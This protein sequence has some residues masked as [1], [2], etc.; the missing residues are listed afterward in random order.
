MFLKANETWRNKSKEWKTW[1]TQYSLV[2]EDVS[3]SMAWKKMRYGE[4]KA[5]VYQKIDLGIPEIQLFKV[6]DPII[7]ITLK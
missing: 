4:T 2:K 7:E 6:Y 5:T 3:E 1:S